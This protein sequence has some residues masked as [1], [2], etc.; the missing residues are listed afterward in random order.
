MENI[1]ERIKEFKLDVKLRVFGFFVIDILG[2]EFFINLRVWG[3]SFC[4]I[5]ILVIDIMYGLEL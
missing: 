4:D 3:F 1:R 2:Y 5:V